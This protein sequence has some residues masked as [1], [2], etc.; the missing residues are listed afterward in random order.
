MCE[1]CNCRNARLCTTEGI[2]DSSFTLMKPDYVCSRA[3]HEKLE[4]AMIYDG[5]ADALSCANECKLLPGC[6][7]FLLTGNGYGTCYW[8]KTANAN[9]PEGWIASFFGFNFYGIGAYVEKSGAKGC[10][11]A[12]TPQDECVRAA[13]YLGYQSAN[14]YEVVNYAHLPH[15]CFVGHEHTQWTYTYYNSNAGTTNAAFK[16]ICQKG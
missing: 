3:T 12:T 10:G 7:Y 2:S 14:G 1:G 5:Y 16:S 8:V 11:E 13:N 15:G 9:C 4:N 6:T